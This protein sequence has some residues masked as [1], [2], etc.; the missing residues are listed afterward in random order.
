M[1][2]FRKKEKK[3]KPLSWS[4]ITIAKHKAIMAVYDKYRDNADD[5]LFPYELT[6]AAYGK[7]WEWIAAMTISEANAYVNS[8]TFL[9]N[10]PKQ[11]R[12]KSK[13]ILNGHTYI[14]C[15]NLTSINTAQYIDFQNLAD[16]CNEL[17][18]EFLAIILIPEGKKYN[19]G[20]ELNDAVSDIENYLTVEEALGLSAFFFNLSKISTM[21]LT[22]KLRR[23]EKKARKEGLMTEEQ[24]DAL[25]KLVELSDSV[26]GLRQW[27]L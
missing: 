3:V 4:D 17:P 12:V 7:P 1:S 13:Y 26:N 19:D 5:D 15:L 6:C 18:A 9:E 11:R 24:L 20:Y 22:Q 2:I 21:R 8:I 10:K 14:A 23:M 25:R 27:P 16:N